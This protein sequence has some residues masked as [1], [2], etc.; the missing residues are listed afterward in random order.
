MLNHIADEFGLR[1]VLCLVG[2]IQ[3]GLSAIAMRVVDLGL[4]LILPLKL[5][6]SLGR[7]C[8]GSCY[9]LLDSVHRPLK[10]KHRVKAAIR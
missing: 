9:Q 6:L 2:R 8:P 4:A 5:G 10:S 7:L 1:I 3:Q